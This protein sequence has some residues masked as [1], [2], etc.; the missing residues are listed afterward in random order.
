MSKEQFLKINGFPNNYWGW[1]GEDDDIFNRSESAHPQT[2]VC[3]V[4]GLHVK[5]SSRTARNT[6]PHNSYLLGKV[7]AKVS[8]ET[9]FL[10]SVEAPSHSNIGLV[11]VTRQ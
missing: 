11:L 6:T 3:G 5:V 4:L 1:G 2:N 7:L 10:F 9:V 8:H